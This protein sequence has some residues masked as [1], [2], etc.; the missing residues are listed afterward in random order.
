[1]LDRFQGYQREHSIVS[2]HSF[3]IQVHE[4]AGRAIVLKLG[5]NAGPT[6]LHRTA[7]HCTPL[8]AMVPC[9]GWRMDRSAGRNEPLGSKNG[10]GVRSCPSNTSTKMRS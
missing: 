6:A 5:A 4:C 8:T 3:V 10:A 7:L 1:M 9:E 2:S